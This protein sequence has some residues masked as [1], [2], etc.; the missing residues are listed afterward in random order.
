M[1]GKCRFIGLVRPFLLSGASGDGLLVLV[2]GISGALKA[3]LSIL[4]PKVLR[5]KP[6]GAPRIIS[7]DSSTENRDFR[8]F[9]LCKCSLAPTV[10]ALRGHPIAHYDR[11]GRGYNICRGSPL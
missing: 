7:E 10:V 1:D 8:T 6:P 5:D 3:G 9:V 11:T 4:T 2:D